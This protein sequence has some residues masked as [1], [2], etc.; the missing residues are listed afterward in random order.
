MRRERILLILGIWVA[1]LPYLGFP[2][3]WKNILFTISGL[4]LV[5]Y[6]YE[7]HK[8]NKVKQLRKQKSDNFNQN[9]MP[10]YE[11]REIDQERI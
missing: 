1:I 2:Y 3:S 9:E 4:V 11:D 10:V 8:E 5:F 7:I 6:S